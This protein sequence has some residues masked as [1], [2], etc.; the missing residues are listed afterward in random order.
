MVAVY[1][2]E[3]DPEQPALFI[4]I[5]R[6]RAYSYAKSKVERADKQADLE[7]ERKDS[8][9]VEMSDLA[10]EIGIE[11]AKEMAMK[12]AA[13]IGGAEAADEEE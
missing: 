13:E 3:N 2:L 8:G 4:Q 1:E 11:I 12:I 7:E 10:I 5:A 9:F 6:L